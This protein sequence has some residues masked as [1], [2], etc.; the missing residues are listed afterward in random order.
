MGYRTNLIMY[1]ETRVSHVEQ[2]VSNEQA[3][4]SARQ[5]A[6]STQVSLCR[7]LQ[8]GYLHVLI[9]NTITI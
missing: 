8:K 1:Q 3:S 9:E 6:R 7:L 4:H 2:P 5:E